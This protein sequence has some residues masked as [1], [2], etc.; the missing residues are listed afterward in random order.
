MS[1]PLKCWVGCRA[2]IIAGLPEFLGT[3]VTCM[4][5]VEDERFTFM[6]GGRLLNGV[7]VNDVPAWRINKTVSVRAFVSGVHRKIDIAVIK[8]ADLMP[9]D[10][11]ENWQDLEK[12]TTL[13]GIK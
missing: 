11:K 5:L 7:K 3:E 6:M 1:K 13:E 4:S 12:G 8:D 10:S 2:V 9:I